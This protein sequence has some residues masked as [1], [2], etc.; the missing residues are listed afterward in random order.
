MKALNS[1]K[2]SV[3]NELFF[4]LKPF[5]SN[6]SYAPLHICHSLLY[7]KG[8]LIAVM[9]TAKSTLSKRSV[10]KIN[11]AYYRFVPSGYD[12]V[13][14]TKLSDSSVA[15]VADCWGVAEGF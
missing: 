4:S 8:Q 11:V 12:A 3:S 13:S 14:A 2:E 6:G 5:S 15:A 7:I 10:L 1:I 9:M